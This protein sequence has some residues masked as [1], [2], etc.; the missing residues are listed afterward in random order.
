MAATAA[1]VSPI[2]S[3]NRPR[4]ALVA[5][6]DGSFRQRLRSVLTGLRWQVREAGGGAEAWG[7]ALHACPGVMIVDSWLPDLDR[8]EF[9]SEFQA[10][11]PDVDVVTAGLGRQEGA[12]GP[13][14]S[15]ILYA[16]RQCQDS[17]TAAWNT[18]PLV[19]EVRIADPSSLRPRLE[20]AAQALA[21]DME[22]SRRANSPRCCRDRINALRPNAFPN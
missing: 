2:R 10:F 9:L 11:F 15:E 4:T 16:L 5:S 21:K 22:R 6:A 1:T 12:P 14:R 18:A 8:D 7:A 17:D 19:D 20:R 3:Q 13:H